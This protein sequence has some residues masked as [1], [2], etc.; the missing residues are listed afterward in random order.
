[1]DPEFFMLKPGTYLDGTYGET[2]L[3]RIV[4]N[5]A[6]PTTDY[7]PHEALKIE[8]GPII[9]SV[10]RNFA[11]SNLSYDTR[12]GKTSLAGIAGFD[13]SMMKGVK[14][15]LKG[16]TFLYKGL[17]QHEDLLEKI[18]QDPASRTKVMQWTRPVRWRRIPVCMITG[19]LLC[20]ESILVTLKEHGTKVAIDGTIPI[21]TAGLAATGAL[22]PAPIGDVGLGGH[23]TTRQRQDAAYEIDEKTI[24]GLE[25][26]IVRRAHWGDELVRLRARAPDLRNNRHLA[27]SDDETGIDGDSD[28]GEETSDSDDMVFGGQ[29]WHFD[30]KVGVMM[31]QL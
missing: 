28:S 23:R 25:L 24:V 27:G 18:M 10:S 2:L 19:I 21:A 11:M 9:T 12:G 13:T 7:R 4:K 14:T 6:Q 31:Q 8:K 17:E 15:E 22:V 30:A 3:G 1:M 29:P 5:Y 16:K 20:E 26:R